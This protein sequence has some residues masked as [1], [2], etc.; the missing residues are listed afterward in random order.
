MFVGSKLVATETA[1]PYSG[2]IDTTTLANGTTT[3]MAVATDNQGANSSTQR[4]VTVNNTVV[5]DPGGGGD[6]TPPSGGGNPTTLPST[7][8]KASR[9]SSR[10]ACTGS[11]LRARRRHLQ[12]PLPQGRRVAR[13]SRASRC[14]T[15]ARNSEC[16]GS[17]VHLTPGT[18][19]EVAVRAAGQQPSARR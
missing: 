17:I 8:T 2:T 5:S 13:G 4:S 11:R 10:S 7:N 1:A 3:L 15:T 9:R 6:P 12:H 16:R 19:Y 18:D 14:G